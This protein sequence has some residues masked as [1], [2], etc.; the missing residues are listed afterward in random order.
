MLTRAEL[1]RQFKLAR[2]S[3]PNVIANQLLY[4]F[5][6]FL[7][8][9]L[10]NVLT[11]GQFDRQ[12]QLVFLIGYLV[13]RV[14]T[15]AMEEMVLSFASDAQWGTLEQVWSSGSSLSTLLFAR[16]INYFLFFT[17]RAVVIAA[18]ILPIVRYEIALVPGALLVYTV[19]LL[20]TVG[21]AFLLIGLHLIYKSVT[22]LANFIAFLLFF[23]TG[24]LSPFENIPTLFAISRVLPL[25][26]GVDVLRAM[27][28]D[29]QRLGDVLNS[30]D[31]WLMLVTSIVY[32][33]IGLA[34]LQYARRRAM[35]D[36]SLAHY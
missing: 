36:G 22:F 32:L 15:G 16:T 23:L 7:L 28:V 3:L 1:G 11:G 13:W 31:F 35:S 34:T 24:V 12:G 27:L 30:A 19:T 20:G 5:I 17:A 6:F 21:L 33:F 18:I 25:S 29:G 26:S 8:S 14:G 9:G 4:I 2:A 10:S